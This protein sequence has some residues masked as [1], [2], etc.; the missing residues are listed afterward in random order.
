LRYGDKKRRRRANW[1]LRR[2]KIAM[3]HVKQ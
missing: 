2:M 1:D 3:F